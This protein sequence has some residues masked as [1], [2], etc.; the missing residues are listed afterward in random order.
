MLETFGVG[1]GAIEEVGD[2]LRGG[3]A[4][5][6]EEGA[7]DG[8][9]GAHAPIMFSTEHT[10]N[11]SRRI[12][13]AS[14][15]H[16]QYFV[17]YRPLPSEGGAQLVEKERELVGELVGELAHGLA[18]AVPRLGLD[19]DQDRARRVALRLLHA[20]GHLPRMHRVDA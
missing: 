2:A 7:E 16:Y 4:R 19:A 20:R 9:L 5:E 17:Q 12:F 10:S 6:K 8:N 18:R 13:L 3:T 15:D 1:A 11:Y 14:R